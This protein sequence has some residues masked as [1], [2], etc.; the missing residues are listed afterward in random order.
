MNSIPIEL[1]ERNDYVGALRLLE[2][3]FEKSISTCRLSKFI[4]FKKHQ[5]KENYQPKDKLSFEVS[6]FVKY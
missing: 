6:M 5:N 2:G 3:T 4:R 1:C